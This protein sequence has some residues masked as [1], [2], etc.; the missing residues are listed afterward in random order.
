M[1]SPDG[2]G[3]IRTPCRESTSPACARRSANKVSGFQRPELSRPKLILTLSD[4]PYP[5]LTSS[6][7]K[8]AWPATD[9]AAGGD[10]AGLGWRGLLQRVRGLPSLGSPPVVGVERGQSAS[11]PIG[12]RPRRPVSPERDRDRVRL[13][14]NRAAHRTLAENDRAERSAS[15]KRYLSKHSGRC[16]A[17]RVPFHQLSGD[18]REAAKPC[19]SDPPPVGEVSAK[20]TEG[21]VIGRWPVLRSS[22]PKLPPPIAARSPPPRGEDLDESVRRGQWSAA[23]RFRFRPGPSISNRSSTPPEDPWP[24]S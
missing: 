1:H 11:M 17:L 4:P 18:P 8:G 5:D 19:K 12:P 20:P 13:S 16:P 24:A 22:T 3:S 14:L 10:R 9:A 21:G 6:Q 7:G 23:P 15:S 2:C